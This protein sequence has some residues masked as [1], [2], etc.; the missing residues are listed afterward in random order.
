MLL[1]VTDDAPPFPRGS[2]STPSPNQPRLARIP[3]RLRLMRTHAY[4]RVA[5]DFESPNVPQ[6]RYCCL[7]RRHALLLEHGGQALV[8]TE[9]VGD[10]EGQLQ[11]LLAVQPA[12]GSPSSGSITFSVFVNKE[13]AGQKTSAASI[14][15]ARSRLREASTSKCP[16]S[17]ATGDLLRTNRYSLSAPIQHGT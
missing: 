11:R 6:Q 4:P 15:G 17:I 16:L 13:S 1:S 5:L 7:S 10:V 2:A 3:P 9:P 14:S 8:A 12:S